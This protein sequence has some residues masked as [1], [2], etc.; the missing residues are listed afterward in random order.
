MSKWFKLTIAL[1]IAISVVTVANALANTIYLP[2]VSK[3]PT[4]TPTITLTPTVTLTPTRTPTPT[5]TPTRTPTATTA[6]G[7]YILDIVYKPS[8]ALNEYV[9]IKNT[10]SKDVDMKN[11][12]I[13]PEKAGTGIKYVFPSFTLKAGKIV[14]V[15]TKSGTDTSTD[16][17]WGLSSP[18][19]NDN[20]D[21]GF[22]KDSDGAPQSTYCY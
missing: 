10:S 5:K 15:W 17:Y 16:L 14:N 8:V 7:V 9:E 18:T 12:T 4:A 3:Y 19:W 20:H 11:W 21:C 13:K 1:V 22:L 6:P 2:M